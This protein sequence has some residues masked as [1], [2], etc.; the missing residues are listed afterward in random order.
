MDK[1]ILICWVGFS[2]RYCICRAFGLVRLLIVLEWTVLFNSFNIELFLIKRVTDMSIW[3]YNLP[4]LA[5]NGC[6]VHDNNYNNTNSCNQQCCYCCCSQKCILHFHQFLL[7]IET[8][9]KS[10]MKLSLWKYWNL[11]PWRHH[12][13]EAVQT[14]YGCHHYLQLTWIM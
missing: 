13:H 7:G 12:D 5:H 6:T 8:L 1:I 11:W 4:L 9:H 2:F 10:L 3:Y 14:L